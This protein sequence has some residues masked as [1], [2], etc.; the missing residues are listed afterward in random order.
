MPNVLNASLLMDVVRE[1][2]AAPHGRKGLVLAR[3]LPL[4]GISLGTF[5]RQRLRVGSPARRKPPKH[6]GQR[7]QP[8]RVEWVKEIMRLKH[9]PMKGVSRLATWNARDLAVQQ[10]MDAEA[11][12][13]SVGVINKIA[14]EE[15]LVEAPRRGARF[16]ARYPNE[17]HQVDATGSRHFYPYKSKGDDWILRIRPGQLPNKEKLEGLRVWCWGLAD[18]FSGYRAQRYVVA[19]GEAA[20]DGIEFLRWCWEA[21]ADHAPF[22]GLPQILYMDNGPLAKYTPFRV[23]CQEV[24]ID[25][26][27][28][29]PYR[30]QAKGKV[31]TGNRDLKEQ[32]EGRFLRDPGWKTR[33]IL[34]SELN[35]EL[36]WFRQQTNAT[37]HRRLPLTKEAAWLRIMLGQGPV[38]LTPESW[39]K[40]FTQHIF[41]TLDDGACFDLGGEAYQVAGRKIWATRVQVFMSVTGEALVVEDLRD[42][43]RYGAIPF[44]APPVGDWKASPKTALELLHEGGQAGQPG[45]AIPPSRITWR[46]AADSNVVP[47]VRPGEERA[48]GFEMPAQAGKPVPPVS[49][50]DLA[51]GITLI[52]GRGDGER[53]GQG[54]EPIYASDLEWFAA[55]LVRQA[56]GEVLNPEIAGRMAAMLEN[57]IGVRLL[58]GDLE[59]RARLAAVE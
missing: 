6:K 49:L 37:P 15:G 50:G 19:P 54:E 7:R 46:P 24:G 11:G 39:E 21:R 43:K 8:D 28:H 17:L 45:A 1:W 40:I 55:M 42:G 25:L 34:L 58:A 3:R 44:V 51:A 57:S 41:R 32:F 26:K 53:G 35:Q 36:A 33:E 29:E 2:E 23:F 20:L 31:E 47:L 30:P 10:G 9:S 52:Q 16:E 48:S 14:R 56:R 59:K 18:D 27:T 5:H 13:M 38:R 22:Q 12:K 4:L